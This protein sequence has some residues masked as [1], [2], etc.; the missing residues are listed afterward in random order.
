MN[1]MEKQTK[2]WISSVFNPPTIRRTDIHFSVDNPVHIPRV[3]DHIQH[4]SEFGSIFSVT[5]TYDHPEYIIINVA[6]K[7]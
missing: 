2:M 7:G 3:G 5:W 6:V 4:G 1:T